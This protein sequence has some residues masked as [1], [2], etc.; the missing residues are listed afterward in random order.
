MGNSR[1]TSPSTTVNREKQLTTPRRLSWDELKKICSLGLCFSCDEKYTPEH[2]CKQPQ[3]FIM[4]SENDEAE[5]EKTEEEES[6]QA[7]EITLHA[8]SGWDTSTTLRLHP[9][10]RGQGL[11]ALVDIGSTHNFIGEK[12][13][14]GLKLKE[15][16]MKP[17]DVQ[18]TNGSPLIC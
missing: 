17:F 1:Y 18:V 9:K 13:A 4:E 3:L 7:P 2:R 8:L 10:L 15:M 5:E 16:M 14:Q 11:V 12:V 6:G